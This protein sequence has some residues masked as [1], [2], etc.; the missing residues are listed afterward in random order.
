MSRGDKFRTSALNLMHG[1]RRMSDAERA[2]L[3]RFADGDYRTKP[4]AARG[5]HLPSASTV[6]TRLYRAGLLSQRYNGPRDPIEFAI[7]PVGRAALKGES[8]G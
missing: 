8:D 1:K 4:D 2:V 6:M 7:T 3:S 5:M